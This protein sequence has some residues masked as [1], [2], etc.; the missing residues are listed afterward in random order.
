MKSSPFITSKRLPNQYLLNPLMWLF[1]PF[2][3]THTH[4]HAQLHISQEYSDTQQWM[5]WHFITLPCSLTAW[6]HQSVIC[7][8]NTMHVLMNI[9][10]ALLSE[11]LITHL[12]DKMALTTGFA[13]MTYQTT[14]VTVCLITHITNIR[15]L[16]TV[17]AFMTYQTT[18]VTVCLITHITNITAFSTMQ[19]LMSYQIAL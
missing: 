8:L 10:T 15:A 12:T 19:S 18:L 4:T 16:T 6:K 13:F 3:F 17:F 1:S 11:C 5:S 14:L 2:D 7:T 9:Q